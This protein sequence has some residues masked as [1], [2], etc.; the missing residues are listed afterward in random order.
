[1]PGYG[2]KKGI[3]FKK[4]SVYEY[5]LVMKGTTSGVVVNMVAECE[6]TV[7]GNGQRDKRRRPYTIGEYRSD[8]WMGNFKPFEP[9]ICKSKGDI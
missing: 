4:K 9:I 1:M 2:K 7:I 5:P 3:P 6:G 8:W